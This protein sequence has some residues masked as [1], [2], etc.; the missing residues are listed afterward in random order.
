MQCHASGQIQRAGTIGANDNSM[1]IMV[2][3][4]S[5]REVSANGSFGIYQ[6]YGRLLRLL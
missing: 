1:E 3:S 5:D 6:V 4:K 2:A